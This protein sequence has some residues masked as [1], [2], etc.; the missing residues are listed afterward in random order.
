MERVLQASTPEA[1]ADERLLRNI[2]AVSLLDG[3]V[4]LLDEMSVWLG[5]TWQVIFDL[6]RFFRSPV[7]GDAVATTYQPFP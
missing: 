2:F 5:K 3:R 4:P 6:K 1:A 7:I